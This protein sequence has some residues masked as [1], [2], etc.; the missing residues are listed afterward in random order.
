M[1]SYRYVKVGAMRPH[2]EF[3]FAKEKYVSQDQVNN[4][5]KQ[6][7]RDINTDFW[8]RMDECSELIN[9]KSDVVTIS[10]KDGLGILNETVQEYNTYYIKPYE[11]SFTT[12][13]SLYIKLNNELDALDENCRVLDSILITMYQY[14]WS[15][16]WFLRSKVLHIIKDMDM[17]DINYNDMENV[18]IAC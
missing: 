6:F 8:L 18:Y 4:Q 2:T 14:L 10:F 7:I 1:V 11:L 12:L 5:L 16:N 17:I 3:R 9:W 13:I 15:A